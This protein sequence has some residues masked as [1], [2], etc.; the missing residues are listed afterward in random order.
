MGAFAIGSLCDLTTNIIEEKASVGWAQRSCSLPL[1]SNGCST[2][3][4][5][6][7]LRIWQEVWGG[8]EG[9]KLTAFSLPSSKDLK[10]RRASGVSA[11]PSH[12]SVPSKQ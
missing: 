4:A 10:M 9:L 3:R 11:G 8:G 2:G 5:R 12:I 1:R 6:E 7:V